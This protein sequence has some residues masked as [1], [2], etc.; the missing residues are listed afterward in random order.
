MNAS[1]LKRNLGH[2]G[3]YFFNRENM[4][5]F[6][7]SMANFGVRKRVICNN[8]GVEVECWELWRKRAVKHGLQSSHYWAVDNFRA[9]HKSN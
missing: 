9:V 3:S 8:R 4:K 1:E 6:G 2:T 5:F 7:D